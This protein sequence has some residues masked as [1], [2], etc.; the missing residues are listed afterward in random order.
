LH[1]FSGFPKFA[2]SKGRKKAMKNLNRNSIV[3]SKFLF[4]FASLLNK[5]KRVPMLG[6]QEF[7]DAIKSLDGHKSTFISLITETKVPTVKKDRQTGEPVDGSV[8]KRQQMQ[9]LINFS[10]ENSVAKRD[11]SYEV[12]QR[13]WGNAFQD[14]FNPALIQNGDNLYLQVMPMKVQYKM[15]VSPDGDISKLENMDIFPKKSNGSSP[16]TVRAFR[17]DSIVAIWIHG[18]E[19]DLTR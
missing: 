8:Y 11:S 15:F 4:T 13:Q 18:K 9:A 1:G 3:S 10:Y 16:V 2:L 7:L 5:K 6:Y 12:G 19:Y 14:K 17:L